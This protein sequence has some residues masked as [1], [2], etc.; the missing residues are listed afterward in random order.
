MKKIA[1]KMQLHQ[2]Q[3]QEYQRRHDEIWTELTELLKNN[4]AE[5]YSIFLD[6]DT[7]A[8][9]GVLK[10]EN[11]ALLDE[12]PKHPIMQKWWKYMSDIMETNPDNSPISTPLKEVFYLS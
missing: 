3:V 2:G 4:G 5:D 10:M 9:F 8:L 12:L 6:P 11:P 1:F 7:N